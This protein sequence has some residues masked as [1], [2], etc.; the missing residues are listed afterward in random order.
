MCKE[1]NYHDEDTA[2]AKTKAQIAGCRVYAACEACAQR[3]VRQADPTRLLCDA[4][5]Q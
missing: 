5:L 2:C 3:G 4:R 1:D